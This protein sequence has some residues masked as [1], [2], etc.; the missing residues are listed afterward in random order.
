M[1]NKLF[2][3]SKKEEPKNY[4]AMT[5]RDLEPGCILEYDL[6]TFEVMEAYEYDWGDNNF[7]KEYK[8]TD[9]KDTLY[10]AVEEDDELE[11]EMSK[12]V[13]IR[14]I[15]E[16]LADYLK[17]HKKPPNSI[18]YKGIKYYYDEESPGYFRNCKNDRNDDDSWTEFMSW[19]CYDD[20]DQHI[21]TLEQWGDNEFD[22]S[23]G[24]VVKEFEISNILPKPNA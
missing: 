20:D 10:F 2:S 24:K 22:A 8:I 7:S 9:G 11:L 23:V 16:D 17:D 13:K 14:K 4:M 12:K 21:L 19:T 18:T 15:Q 6:R 1:F 5:V 3:R